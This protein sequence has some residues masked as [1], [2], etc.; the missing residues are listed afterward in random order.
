MEDQRT[1]ARASAGRGGRDADRE[2]AQA[3]ARAAGFDT[4]FTGYETVEQ[5]TAVGAIA[6]E[7]GKVLAKLVESPFYATGGGQVH[8]GGEVRC[9]SGDCAARVT[10]VLRIGD[11]QV[12]V[13]EPTQ[14][15][16]ARGRAR[17]RAR[18]PR[19]APRDRVQPHRHP[20]PARRAA[21]AAR[22]ATCAR[23]APTSAP[24]SCASTSPTARR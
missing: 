8:D 4:E 20:P 6:Q 21:R 13:L 18:R 1:R 23:P 3:F 7:N 10:D 2:R 17:R 15:R 16:A 24:T 12:L 9:E 11:D 14:G 22:H 5:A 19:G